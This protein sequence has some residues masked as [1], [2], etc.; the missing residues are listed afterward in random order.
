M[1]KTINQLSFLKGQKTVL[2]M[3]DNF[4]QGLGPDQRKI[5]CPSYGEPSINQILL[6]ILSP[7]QNIYS[8]GK[9][10]LRGISDQKKFVKSYLS[11]TELGYYSFCGR[12]T[13]AVQIVF[14]IILSCYLSVLFSFFEKDVC[15]NFP[16]A[17]WCVMMDLLLLCIKQPIKNIYKTS[18]C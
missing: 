14:M 10:R 9:L 1:N 15:W 5:F 2:K 3:T 12:E 13:H 11:K 17:T 16:E 4:Q 18:W 6:S 7:P 8:L